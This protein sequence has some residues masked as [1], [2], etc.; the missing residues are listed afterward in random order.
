M[1]ETH[2]DELPLLQQ[3]A[4]CFFSDEEKR[5][6]TLETDRPGIGLVTVASM[7]GIVTA[8]CS[9]GE[10]S[11]A[12]CRQNARLRF[13]MLTKARNEV[14]SEFWITHVEAAL[15]QRFSQRRH[16]RHA[17]AKLHLNC[18]PSTSATSWNTQSAAVLKRE[19][20]LDGGNLLA[21]F[22]SL[23]GMQKRIDTRHARH[24]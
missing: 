19:P 13:A 11:A 5:A 1:A 12:L 15:V 24:V 18:A 14:A 2:K 21:A 23:T 7:L 3:P 4:R 6:I 8:R 9:A 22:T 17:L 10:C 16:A 20:L